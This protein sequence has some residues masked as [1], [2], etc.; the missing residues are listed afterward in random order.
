MELK[1]AN[2]ISAAGLQA[3]STRMRVLSENLANAQST[4]ETP[5]ADPYR[6]KVLTF[7]NVLNRDL[8]ADVVEVD[9]IRRDF[10]NDF[11]LR[12]EPGHPAADENGYVKYPNVNP[13]IELM[14]MRESQRSYDANISAIEAA[15]TMS[16]RTLELLRPR[17]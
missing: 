1:R 11:T 2:E 8:G 12:H 13:L 17:M 5:G 3:Q 6:R 10:R 9:K 16:R 7:K 4:G 15:R 14:D